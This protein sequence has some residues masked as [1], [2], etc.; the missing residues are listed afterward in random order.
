MARTLVFD[1]DGLAGTLAAGTPQAVA[2]VGVVIGARTLTVD[3]NGPNACRATLSFNRATGVVSGTFRL[4]VT[5]AD[6]TETTVTASYRGVM[7][8]GWGPGCG[9]EDSSA[10]SDVKLPFVSGAFWVADK[11]TDAATGRARTVKRGGAAD[12]AVPA[13]VEP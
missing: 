13:A 10:A 12:I 1:V 6:D 4:P 7:L 5:K 9:C 2:P 3:P 11:A 8:I